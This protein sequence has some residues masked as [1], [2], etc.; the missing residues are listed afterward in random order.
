MFTL[1][2]AKNITITTLDA[3]YKI[4]YAEKL[5]IHTVKNNIEDLDIPDFKITVENEFYENIDD[6]VNIDT[7]LPERPLVDESILEDSEVITDKII[8]ELYKKILDD[9]LYIIHRD[10]NEDVSEIDNILALL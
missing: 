4:K 8:R 6:R 7:V 5:E 3:K 1:Y 9:E 2:N 10:I